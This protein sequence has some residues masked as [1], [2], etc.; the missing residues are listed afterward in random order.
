MAKI[1]LSIVGSSPAFVTTQKAD[2]LNF[3]DFFLIG[4]LK[5]FSATKGARSFKIKL[6]QE[7][8]PVR[9]CKVASHFKFFIVLSK[10]LRDV[11]F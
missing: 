6:L 3:G 8:E 1:D 10:K 4:L 9:I 7:I 5:E 2:I 11:Y